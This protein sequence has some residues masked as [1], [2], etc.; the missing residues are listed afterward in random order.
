MCFALHFIISYGLIK[1]LATIEIPLLFQKELFCVVPTFQGRVIQ[2][3]LL[4]LCSY[5]QGSVG[6]LRSA[7][8]SM[9][10]MNYL[11]LLGLG[12]D[13]SLKKLVSAIALL[14]L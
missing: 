6:E 4:L 10:F 2:P 1:T 8:K 13:N 12:E 11:P 5:F 14:L 7:S 3:K 9:T